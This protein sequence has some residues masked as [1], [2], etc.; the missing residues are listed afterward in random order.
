[1]STRCTHHTNTCPGGSYLWFCMALLFLCVMSCLKYT[2]IDTM[3]DFAEDNHAYCTFF[4]FSLWNKRL[5][6]P[7]IKMYMWKF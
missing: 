4:V 5:I 3:L 6:L 2:R 7:E 1:M